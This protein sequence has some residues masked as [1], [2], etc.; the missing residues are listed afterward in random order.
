MSDLTAEDRAALLAASMAC[1]H[2]WHAALR[3]HEKLLEVEARCGRRAKDYAGDYL[4]RRLT[5]ARIDMLN[6]NVLIHKAI[7]DRRDV[8]WV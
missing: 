6:I 7:T 4:T 5:D 8:E 3:A 2:A 1:G